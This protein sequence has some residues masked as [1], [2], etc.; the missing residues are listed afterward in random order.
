ME[1]SRRTGAGLPTVSTGRTGITNCASSN[2][3]TVLRRSSLSARNRSSRPTRSGLPTAIGQSEAEQER[4]RSEQRP[5]QNKLGL[6]NLASGETTTM[7]AIESFSFSPDGAYLAL[8]PYGPERAAAAAAPAAGGRGGGRGGGDGSAAAE[9][10]LGTSLVVRHL[11]SGRDT[12]FGNVSQYAWQDAERSH[13]LAMIISAVGQDR[14]RRAVVR[15]GNHGP[16]CARFFVLPF[17]PTL[18][19]G[20]EIRTWQCFVRRPTTARMAPPMPCWPGPIWAR[21]NASGCTIPPRMLHSRQAC[22]PSRSAGSRGRTTAAC[23]FWAS[24]S[25]MTR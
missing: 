15:S 25:G 3:P 9:E 12:S 23:C 18:R 14:Q 17:I 20:G 2:L 22:G 6:L 21:T 8:R 11:A 19:G 24:P 1:A 4:L 5:V 7:D 16:A 10:A 13:L